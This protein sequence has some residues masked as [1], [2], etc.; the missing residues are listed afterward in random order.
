MIKSEKGDILLVGHQMIK[1]TD[2]VSPSLD[3]FFKKTSRVTNF[4]F[5][6]KKDPSS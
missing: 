5:F 3:V 6:V 1:T 4:L 2:E